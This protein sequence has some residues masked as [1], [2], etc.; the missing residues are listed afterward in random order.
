MNRGS[1]EQNLRSEGISPA[2]SLSD[3]E[4]VVCQTEHNLMQID[5]NGLY[6][7]RPWSHL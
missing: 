1:R 7:A 4:S 2:R 5:V 3:L 6:G